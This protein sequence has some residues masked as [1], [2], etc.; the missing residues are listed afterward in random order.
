MTEEEAKTKWC[1][2]VQR[3]EGNRGDIV[4]IASKCMMWRWDDGEKEYWVGCKPPTGEGWE[5][6]GKH[7]GSLHDLLDHQ[8]IP[9]AG[10][11]WQRKDPAREGYCGL[12][13]KP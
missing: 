7:H 5:P 4:C 8:R 2:M 13:G 10:N 1:P 12:G 6:I 9:P 11:C 3:P